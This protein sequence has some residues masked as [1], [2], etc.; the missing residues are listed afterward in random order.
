MDKRKEIERLL[1]HKRMYQARLVECTQHLHN[2]YDNPSAYVKNNSE[3][4]KALDLA[5]M[6]IDYFIEKIAS[7]D[8]KIEEEKVRLSEKES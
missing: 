8:D 2:L 6:D 7:I 5:Y 3:L 1:A 4:D